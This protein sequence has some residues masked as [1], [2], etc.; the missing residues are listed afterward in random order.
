MFRRTRLSSALTVAFGGTVLLAAHVETM[1]QATQ[2]VEVTGSLIRRIDGESALPTVT[3]DLGS[4]EKA[5]VTNAEQVVRFITQAQGGSVSSGSV[6]GTNGAAAYAELRSLGS[7]RTLVLLNGKR[8]VANPY[9]VAGVDLN[10]IPMSAIERIETLPDGASATY[11]TDA[12]AG[13]INFITKRSYKGLSVSGGAQVTQHGGADVYTGNLLGGIGDLSSQGWNIYGGLNYREGKPMRG[14]DREFSKSSYR[15][16]LGFNGLSATTFPA[17][18]SQTVNGVTTVANANPSL[19][20]CQPP[21]SII[22]SAVATNRCNAD[23]QIFTNTVPEQWQYSGY[24]K[25]SLALGTEHTAT[26][27]YFNAY[28]RIR[29]TIAPSPETGLTMGPDSPYYPGKGIT[30]LTNPALNTSQ[31]ISVSWRTTVL[32]SRS[33]GQENVTQRVL[34]GL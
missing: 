21:S 2:R 6:S 31:P 25:G 11:G 3:L 17:N 30:P 8:I 19:P 4:L 33:S 23:T 27:E 1:A 26:L 29:T 13:V 5:G 16:D 15:P 12:I 10:T 7:N 24:V 9:A 32:G 18:Y 22:A 28:N 34:A 20:G 14:T